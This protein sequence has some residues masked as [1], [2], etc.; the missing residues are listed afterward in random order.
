MSFPVANVLI[1]WI[2]TFPEIPVPDTDIY[3][4]SAGA[5]TTSLQS[6]FCNHFILRLQ[7]VPKDL[8]YTALSPQPLL[9][10]QVSP[11]IVSLTWRKISLAKS[12]NS[13]KLQNE[14]THYQSLLPYGDVTENG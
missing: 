13:T 1:M 3:I 9:H 5:I 4:L 12:L 2:S 8:N 11:F 10:L 14:M 7:Y 6:C